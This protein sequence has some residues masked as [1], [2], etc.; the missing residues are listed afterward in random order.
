[1]SIKTLK[2]GYTLIGTALLVLTASSV[3]QA[4][5][6]LHTNQKLQALEREKVQLEASRAVLDQKIA[7]QTA[8]TPIQHQLA[9]DFTPITSFF[10][11]VRHSTVA[12]R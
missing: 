2:I 9:A 12:L 4:S 5:C 3:Y 10:T 8:L 7:T 6:A 1:M 11:A